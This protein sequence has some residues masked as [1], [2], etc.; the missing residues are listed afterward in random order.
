MA[1]ADSS[2]ETT[3]TYIYTG[4][5]RKIRCSEQAPCEGCI[6]TGIACT[7]VKHPAVRGPRKLRKSTL[8]EISQTQ[9]QQHWQQLNLPQPPEPVDYTRLDYDSVFA[10][11]KI[12]ALVLQ[13]C[14]FRLRV[15]PICKCPR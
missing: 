8:Q 3:E 13:L 1:L 4:K 10:P 2:N 14:I 15:Y 9:A 6:A 12:A 5:I 11:A 7:F